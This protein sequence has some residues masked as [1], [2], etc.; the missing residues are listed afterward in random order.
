MMKFDTFLWKKKEIKLQTKSFFM[1]F[2]WAVKKGLSFDCGAPYFIM[3]I[4]PSKVNHSLS[5][6][7]FPTK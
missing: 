6:F 2:R 5:H 7:S 3:E 1:A 4:K